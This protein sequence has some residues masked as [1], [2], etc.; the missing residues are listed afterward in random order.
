MQNL[1]KEW[2][3]LSVVILQQVNF[4][5]IFILCLW[6]LIIRRSNERVQFMN[7]PSQIFFNDISHG[8]RAASLKKNSL[9]LLLLYVAVASYCY[10]EKIRRTMRTTI[11]SYLLKG[12]VQFMFL[13]N[14]HR[15]S[16]NVCL[17]KILHSTVTKKVILRFYAQAKKTFK[18]SSFCNIS[19]FHNGFV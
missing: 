7:F 6:L 17:M 1:R 15:S 2:K 10:H 9:W 4:Y 19:N 11:V 14:P 5:N 3:K 12:N 18:D 13:C 8:Y 16:V